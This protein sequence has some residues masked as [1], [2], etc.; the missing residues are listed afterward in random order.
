M[1]RSTAEYWMRK[2]IRWAVYQRP[3]G[4][5]RRV[6]GESGKLDIYCRLRLQNYVIYCSLVVCSVY[7]IK[8]YCIGHTMIHV[9]YFWILYVLYVEVFPLSIS[10]L[11]QFTFFYPQSILS[12]IVHSI[13]ML[14]ILVYALCISGCPHRMCYLFIQYVVR[15]FAI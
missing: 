6:A 12:I 14:S 13:Y 1:L 10:L 2:S 4:S 3:C 11:L 8:C 15:L 5:G 9:I 7:F